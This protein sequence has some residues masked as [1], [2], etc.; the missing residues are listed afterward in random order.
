[1][2]ELRAELSARDRDRRDW[3]LTGNLWQVLLTIGAPLAIYQTLS[4]LFRILDTMMA[5]HIGA[6]SVSAVAYL[7]Q[8]N[9]LLSAV[10]AGLAVGA[11]IKIS[12]AYGAGDYML[13]KRRVNT[14]L[15]ICCLVGGVML[16]ALLP[17]STQILR[18]AKTPEAFIAE[19]RAYF[20]VN[21]FDMVV[22]FFNNIYIAV[23]RSRGNSRLILYLNLASVAV[24]LSLTALF[25]YGLGSGIT[26][27]A[28]ATLASDLVILAV[29]LVNLNRPGSAFGLSAAAVTFRREVAGPMLQL[30]APVVAEK[31]AFS[32]GKVVVNSMSAGYGALTVGALGISNN[33]GGLTSQP[34]SGFQEGGAAVI[35]Q[36]LGAGNPARALDAFRRLLVINVAIGALGHLLTI[37]FLPGLVG[38]FA[39]GDAEFGQVIASIYRYEAI[40]CIP[41]GVGSAVTALLYGFGYTKLTLLINFCRVFV[42]RIPV[43]WALQRFTDLG[44]QSVGVVMMVSHWLTALFAL[45]VAVRAVRHIRERYHIPSRNQ[46]KEENPR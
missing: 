44:S 30:G 16:A 26:M 1:M 23:E 31:I 24:K 41:L 40:G 11:S 27:I 22:T 45:A 39:S 46:T 25:V 4:Q 13:V 36:N 10:G 14:L 43:L 2:A 38:L 42:F 6:S 3:I 19:G 28:V 32:F 37:L 35:S 5:A 17:F 7:S 9:L 15:A 20:I 8:I 21:L 18:L 12:E 29:G 33:I 34:Q